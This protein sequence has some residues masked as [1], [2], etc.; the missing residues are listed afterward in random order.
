M[1]AIIQYWTGDL[2]NGNIN[3]FASYEG[4]FADY[5]EMA[6]S[7]A[8]TDR[9]DEPDATPEEALAESMAFHYVAKVT[10]TYDEDG[11]VVKEDQETLDGGDPDACGYN[12]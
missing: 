8:T 2:S 7:C 3:P 6:E 9:G 12:G 11:K 5:K 4:A 1:K 10:T